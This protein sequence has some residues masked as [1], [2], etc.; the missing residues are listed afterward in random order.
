MTTLVLGGRFT[1][2][3][4]NLAALVYF[5][6]VN[7]LFSRDIFFSAL[8]EN[9]IAKTQEHEKKCRNTYS[10]QKKGSRQ[11][12]MEKNKKTH[13]TSLIFSPKNGSRFEVF[14]SFL[15]YFV[16]LFVLQ[17]MSQDILKTATIRLQ[18]NL[19]LWGVCHTACTTNEQHDVVA[20]AVSK[21]TIKTTIN[22]FVVCFILF[23]SQHKSKHM[24]LPQ[25][26][27]QRQHG[28]NN[29]CEIAKL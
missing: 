1:I 12:N 23:L 8:K 26:S 19:A 21:D 14:F 27:L 7:C 25:C 2:M 11:Q 24:L 29:S 13:A 4:L 10:L 15:F 5:F 9:K 3:F 22:V 18:D 6:T 20:V 17:K 28:D 16:F